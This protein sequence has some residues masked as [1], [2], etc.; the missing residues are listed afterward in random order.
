[1]ASSFIVRPMY[2]CD[3]SSSNAKIQMCIKILASHH[4]VSILAK[5]P[6]VSTNQELDFDSEIMMSM[7]FKT[8]MEDK[9]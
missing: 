3:D 8:N 4:N 7:D 1:M 5:V 6:A 2:R 9:A